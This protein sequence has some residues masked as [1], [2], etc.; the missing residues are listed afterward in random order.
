MSDHCLRR[1]ERLLWARQIDDLNESFWPIGDPEHSAGA[2]GRRGIGIGLFIVVLWGPL[3]RHVL[4]WTTLKL[5][6]AVVRL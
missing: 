5:T 2:D 3:G 6:E 4:V 1:G